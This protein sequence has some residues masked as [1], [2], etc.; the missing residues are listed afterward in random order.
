MFSWF[1]DSRSAGYGAAYNVH[2]C[3]VHMGL[4]VNKKSSI[5]TQFEKYITY[6][7]YIY[8]HRCL[9]SNGSSKGS[10]DLTLTIKSIQSIFWPL[11]EGLTRLN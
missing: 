11:V 2:V 3:S 6:L 5:V 4:D 1:S 10:K 8:H 7:G 9:D